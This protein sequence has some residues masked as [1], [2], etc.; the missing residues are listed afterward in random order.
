MNYAPPSKH[1]KLLY[2]DYGI[3]D[4]KTQ[5]RGK[6]VRPMSEKGYQLCVVIVS[7][8]DRLS[9]SIVLLAQLIVAY[10]EPGEQVLDICAGTFAMACAGM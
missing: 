1:W 7:A 5:T 6:R 9:P 2:T 3:K 4:K 8:Y 10:T